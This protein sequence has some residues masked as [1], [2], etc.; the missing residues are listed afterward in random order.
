MASAVVA[1][2]HDYGL[3]GTVVA[4]NHV[5]GASLAQRY[6]WDYSTEV[7]EDA[8][9][10]VNVTPLGMYGDEENTQSFSDAEINS[11]ALIID[12]VAHPVNTPLIR[13][14]QE[15]NKDI[16]TGGDIIALQAAEQFAL[17]TGVTPSK[18]Q[19]QSAEAFASEQ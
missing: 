18:E 1:A 8:R 11:A 3:T 5:T 10:L 9:I 4:R 13:A 17:Y 16:I 14:A 6:G 19:I 2:L 12:A 15:K 7:P